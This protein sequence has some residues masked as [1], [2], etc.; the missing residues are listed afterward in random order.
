MPTSPQQLKVKLVGALTSSMP[1][2]H[3]SYASPLKTS[4]LRG[5]SA[6][7]SARPAQRPAAAKAQKAMR[8]LHL[9]SKRQACV[10]PCCIK[11]MRTSMSRAAPSRAH[12][13]CCEYAHMHGEVLDQV[14]AGIEPANCLFLHTPFSSQPH[15]RQVLDCSS[16]SVSHLLAGFSG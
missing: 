1:C 4:R 3:C 13:R 2:K 6:T 11:A 10:G 7:D 14:V 12:Q 16:R 8:T 9:H 15:Y 5:I